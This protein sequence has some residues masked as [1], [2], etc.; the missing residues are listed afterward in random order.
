M[1][2]KTESIAPISAPRCK[3]CEEYVVHVIGLDGEERVSTLT[4]GYDYVNGYI[5]ALR[6][7]CLSIA[8]VERRTIRTDDCT[9][10]FV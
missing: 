1:K 3:T 4:S 7:A 9:E 6:L 10:E 5:D 8:K 2:D